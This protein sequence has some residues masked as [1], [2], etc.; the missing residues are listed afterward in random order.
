MPSV[1]GKQVFVGSLPG[2]RDILPKAPADKEVQRDYP[3]AVLALALPDVK[4]MMPPYFGDVLDPEPFYFAVPQAGAVHDQAQEVGEFV[5]PGGF[6]HAAYDVDVVASP[7]ARI[8]LPRAKGSYLGEDVFPDDA[9]HEEMGEDGAYGTQV[10]VDGLGFFPFLEQD[11]LQAGDDGGRDFREGVYLLYPEIGDKDF[12]DEVAVD[13]AC[14][15]TED[16]VPL[17]VNREVGGVFPVIVFQDGIE[18]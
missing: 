10:A 14:F 13:A 11:V 5:F 17:A 16:T 18:G 2:F 3:D 8:L 4:K 7:E 9:G 15:F 6:E 12:F 1:P